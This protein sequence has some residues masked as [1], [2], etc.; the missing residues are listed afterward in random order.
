MKSSIAWKWTAG[1]CRRQ[2][3]A[4]GLLDRRVVTRVGMPQNADTRIAVQYA[5][6][7][8]L[9]LLPTVS[10]DGDAGADAVAAQTVDCNQICARRRIQQRIK[11][12]PVRDRVGAILHVFR[13][14]MWQRCR[15][16]IEVIAPR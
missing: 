8:C 3:K 14:P 1:H 16:R 5:L 12:R 2:P 10:D 6:Q 7:P 9:G 13:L 11:D 4:L 15:S